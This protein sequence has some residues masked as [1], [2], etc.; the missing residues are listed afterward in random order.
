MAGFDELA[1]KYTTVK[2]IDARI[3]YLKMEISAMRSLKRA[4]KSEEKRRVRAASGK[5][6]RGD[7]EQY[8]E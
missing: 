6:D 5:P 3:L 2:E 1:G 7:E 4:R 8:D